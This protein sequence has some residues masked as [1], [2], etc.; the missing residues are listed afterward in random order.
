[1]FLGL[2]K[3]DSVNSDMQKIGSTLVPKAILAGE[4]KS[5]V[6]DLIQ[7]EKNLILENNEQKM[8]EI[9]ERMIQNYKKTSEKIKILEGFINQEEK[10]IF[11]DFQKEFS[12]FEAVDQEITKLAMLNNSFKATKLSL[13]VGQE[14]VNKADEAIVGLSKLF[15][16]RIFDILHS[17]QVNSVDL[18][19]ILDA[20]ELAVNINRHLLNIHQAQKNVILENSEEVQARQ[21]EI[22]TRSKDDIEIEMK[23]LKTLSPDDIKENIPALKMALDEY[24]DINKQVCDM[25][26]ANTQS[27]AYQLSKTKSHE[28][29]EKSLNALNTII[30]KSNKGLADSKKQSAENFVASRNMTLIVGLLGIAVAIVI[31]LFISRSILNQLGLD[32]ADI[33]DIVKQAA[34]GD[35]EIL[36]DSKKLKGVYGDIKDM[37]NTMQTQAALA[38]AIAAGDLTRN[39]KA[40]SDRDALGLALGEMTQKLNS[41]LVQVN[42]AVS[43]VASGSGQVSDSSQSLSQGASQQ[44]A[45]LVQIT[46][47]MTELTS[48]TKTNAENAAQASN[49]AMSAKAAAQNGSEQMTEMTLAMKGIND[50]SR[51]IAKIIKS[52]DDIAFQTNLLAL[53]AAVEAARAGKQGKGFAVVAQEVRNLAGR[54]AKA[55]QETADL[56]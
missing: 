36:F 10:A 11:N 46:S 4:I 39:I 26:L 49:I 29:V 13:G 48:Q 53:N 51:E 31:G 16:Q 23:N 44:A 50:S 17:D 35:V 19:A 9:N 20:F 33:S 8:K 56:I 21:M 27:K 45:S 3:L 55:A 42:E 37:V 41:V 5:E 14:A 32:P 25:A 15:R 22:M 54:S 40:A 6:L 47:S 52:I 38:Q 12:S 28:A 34:A 30:E 24:L 7:D 2:W 18:K 1:G 43:Q